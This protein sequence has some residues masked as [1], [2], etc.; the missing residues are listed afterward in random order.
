MGL[1]D[2]AAGLEVTERQRE[3][4][5]PTVDGTETD[6]VERL[7]PH[8]DDLPCTPE[9]T[10]TVLERHAAGA[11]VGE[12]ARTAGVAPI[13]A[14]KALHRCG[15]AGL[16]PLGPEARRMVRDWL[17]GT[18]AR[19]EAVTLARAT[20]TEFALAT[21]IETHDPVPAIVEAVEG[22]N[23]PER[24][25]TVEKREALAETMSPVSDLQ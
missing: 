3:R 13:T 4:G 22:I 14:A 23:E 21:Y 18:L 25:A 19:T 15:V 1:S 12:S 6:L 20:E 17:A 9:A 24:S 11:D 10:A 16:S 8:A 2:L 7:E 5:V